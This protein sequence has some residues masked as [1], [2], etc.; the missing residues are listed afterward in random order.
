M[1]DNRHANGLIKI[2]N[3]LD[4]YS[5]KGP[6]FIAREPILLDHKRVIAEPDVYVIDNLGNHH[7]FEYKSSNNQHL[8]ARAQLVRA[9]AFIEDHIGIRPALYGVFGDYKRFE[10]LE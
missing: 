5:I 10:R 1:K 9:G 2:I 6:W 3:N 7:I 8:K 4:Y